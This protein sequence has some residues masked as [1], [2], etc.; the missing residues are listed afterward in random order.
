MI[1]RIETRKERFNE[2]DLVFH[3]VFGCGKSDEQYSDMSDS[4]II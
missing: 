2:A 1:L 3:I 4:D